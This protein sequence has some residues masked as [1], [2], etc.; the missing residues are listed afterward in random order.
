MQTE[1]DVKIKAYENSLTKDQKLAIKNERNRLKELKEKRSKVQELKN[2]SIEN[3]KPKRSPGAFL[4]FFSDEARKA[5][6]NVKDAKVKFEALGESQKNA[7]AQ[8]A[9][10]LREEYKWVN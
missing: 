10:A 5:K 3:G 1:Y 9:V 2:L 4:L 8:K 7:Y 6:T